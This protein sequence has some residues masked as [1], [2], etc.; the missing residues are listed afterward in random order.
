MQTE[1]SELKNPP[2]NVWIGWEYTPENPYPKLDGDPLVHVRFKDVAPENDAT[3]PGADAEL[4]ADDVELDLDNLAAD[5]DEFGAAEEEDPL[6][7]SAKM[8][9][10]ARRVA[11]MRSLVESARKLK[12]T[13]W[14]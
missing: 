5:E 13:K 7:R 1:K 2:F 14:R 4:A 11:E 10:L 12:A 8:E 6:G 3:A 9:S